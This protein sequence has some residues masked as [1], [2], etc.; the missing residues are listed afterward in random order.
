MTPEQT[1]VIFDEY[2]AMNSS[3]DEPSGRMMDINEKQDAMVAPKS[4]TLD[5][6]TGKRLR[7]ELNKKLG[8]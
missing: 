4:E 8:R 6:D 1:S 2:N 3:G 7:E 5:D